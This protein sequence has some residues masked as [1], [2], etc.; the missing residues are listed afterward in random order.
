MENLEAGAAMFRAWPKSIFLD[1]SVAL[2]PPS[3][4]DV[5]KQT[6]PCPLTSTHL[7]I[8]SNIITFRIHFIQYHARSYISQ[9]STLNEISKSIERH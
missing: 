4:M 5:L 7:N 9:I 3:R 6:P 2:L 1:P 8:F